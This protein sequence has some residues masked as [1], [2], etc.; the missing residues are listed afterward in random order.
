M[1]SLR[2]SIRDANIVLFYD[3]IATC[4]ISLIMFDIYYYQPD[5][6]SIL[7]FSILE[8]LLLIIPIAFFAFKSGVNTKLALKIKAFKLKDL[9]L[10]LGLC[11][12][13]YIIAINIAQIVTGILLALGGTIPESAFDE[14]L[15]S[16]PIWLVLYSLII[17]APFFEEFMMRG[18][19][20]SGYGAKG[21]HAAVW[22]TALLFGLMHGD[23]IS[24]F[25]ATFLG[26]VLGYIA[27]GTGCIWLCVIYHALHNLFAYTGVLDQ[28]VMQLPWTLGRMPSLQTAQGT[29]AYL[30]YDFILLIIAVCIF[31]VLLRLI[32]KRL[33]SREPRQAFSY[34]PPVPHKKGTLYGLLIAGGRFICYI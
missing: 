2:Y 11:I 19:L 10:I 31:A 9:F 17:A 6:N 5:L 29:A 23:I 33:P 27:T 15:Y 16:S 25:T 7:V 32:L 30:V 21:P 26:V 1:K 3:A 14:E 22:I 12:S 13:G 18:L 20:L 4:M 8:A 28:Y 24:L 34:E